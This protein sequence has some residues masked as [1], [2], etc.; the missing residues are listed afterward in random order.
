MSLG[1]ETWAIQQVCV[2][3]ILLVPQYVFAFTLSATTSR[4]EPGKA[5]FGVPSP[6]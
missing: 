4:E 2:R 6:P 5:Y 1:V 3:I